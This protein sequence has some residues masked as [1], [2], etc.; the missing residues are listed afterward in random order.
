M[1][2]CLYRYKHIHILFKPVPV[3]M[4]DMDVLQQNQVSFPKS[5]ADPLVKQ[6]SPA[7]ANSYHHLAIIIS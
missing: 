3:W 5:P 4:R 1:A 2:A 6:Y 7:Y